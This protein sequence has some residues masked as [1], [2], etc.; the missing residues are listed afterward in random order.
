MKR[1]LAPVDGSESSLR[2]IKHLIK[3]LSNYRDPKDLEIHLLTVQHPVPGD[4]NMFVDHDQIKRY[5][6]E[7]GLKALESARQLL[8]EAGAIYTFH[9]SVGDPAEVIAIFAKEKH[10]DQI[11]MGT[12]GL[13]DIAGLILGSISHKVLH[14]SDVPVLLVK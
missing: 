13:S 2:A 10:C 8:D 9:I 3:K 5:H 11:I 6:H 1:V 14:L 4:V 12:R 7:E